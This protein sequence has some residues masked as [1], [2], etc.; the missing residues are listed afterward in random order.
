MAKSGQRRAF[1]REFKLEAV[2]AIGAGTKTVRQVAREMGVR[3]D[4][5]HRWK[6][7]LETRPAGER[8]REATSQDEEVRRLR[9]ELGRV[10]EER[11]ILKKATAFFARESR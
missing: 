5:I 6:R 3:P 11:D 7:Q 10:T 9:A 4:L 2:R 1:S 8:T